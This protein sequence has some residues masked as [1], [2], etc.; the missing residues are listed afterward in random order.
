MKKKYL[1]EFM[2]ICLLG[3]TYKSDTYVDY[4]GSTILDSFD[5]LSKA[6]QECSNIANCELIVDSG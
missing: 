4:D 3:Y 6:I 1:L 5:D 2:I